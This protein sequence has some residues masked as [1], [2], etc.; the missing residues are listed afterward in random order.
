VDPVS[1][2][3]ETAGKRSDPLLD[4]EGNFGGAGGGTNGGALSIRPRCYWCSSVGMEGCESSLAHTQRLL[5]AFPRQGQAL[6]AVE[7]EDFLVI[8]DVAFAAQEDR[9]PSVA[10]AR[11]LL[12]K[13]AHPSRES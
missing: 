5:A 12:R 11:P 1:T 3:S 7:T 6:G 9:E 8:D 10:E 2:V 13:L 4:A